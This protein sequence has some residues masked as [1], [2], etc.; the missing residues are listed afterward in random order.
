MFDQ[1]RYVIAVAQKMNS[2][3]QLDL[4]AKP[5]QRRA[6]GPVADDEDVDVIPRDGQQFGGPNGITHAFLRPQTSYEA[7]YELIV[8]AGETL[9]VRRIRIPLKKTPGDFFQSLYLFPF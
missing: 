3:L 8:P 5:L 4:V 9:T 6:L 1:L 7:E 2:A